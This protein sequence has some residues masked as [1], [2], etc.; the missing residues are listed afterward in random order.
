MT[1]HSDLALKQ[2]MEQCASE[3]IHKLSTIQPHGIALVLNTNPVHSIIQASDNLEELLKIS[4]DL[5]L[6]QPLHS[7]IGAK[8][9]AQVNQLIATAQL[10]NTNTA[11]GVID[12]ISPNFN[13]LDAHVYLS[14]EFPVLELS[15]DSHL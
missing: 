13:K 9:A 6:D 4:A 15:N 14:D 7:V 3:P 2:A 11:M 1:E 5:A 8:A 10:S 12:F